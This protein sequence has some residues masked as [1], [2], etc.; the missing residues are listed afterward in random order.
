MHCPQ[1]ML[2]A[3]RISRRG[4]EDRIY[5]AVRADRGPILIIHPLFNGSGGKCA[6]AAEAA[7]NL[8]PLQLLAMVAGMAVRGL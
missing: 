2:L 6:A 4:A 3:H 8:A 5:A 1:E 7:A